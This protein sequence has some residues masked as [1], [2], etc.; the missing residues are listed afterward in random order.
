MPPYVSFFLLSF[1]AMDP[2]PNCVAAAC[3][4]F[5]LADLLIMSSVF[6]AKVG[7]KDALTSLHRFFAR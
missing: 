6:V 1:D 3:I 7:L 5:V 2:S 4:W